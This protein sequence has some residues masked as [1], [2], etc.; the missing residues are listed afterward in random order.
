MT[1]IDARGKQL[2]AITYSEALLKMHALGVHN[3]ID[4]HDIAGEEALYD[5]RIW[6]Q[7]ALDTVETFVNANRVILDSI[8]AER[9]AFEGYHDADWQADRGMDPTDP[10]N[11]IRIVFDMA[12]HGAIDPDGPDRVEMEAEIDE[13]Q[14]ALDM[15]LDLLGLHGEK[16]ASLSGPT[17][18][19]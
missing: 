13:Q 5:Q 4:E 8:G 11:A 12:R 18:A 10:L 9:H 19:S 3:Q 7:Q 1:Y 16:V 6:Q 17:L 15:T 14:Q 2:E